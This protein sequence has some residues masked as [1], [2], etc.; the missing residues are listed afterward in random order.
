VLPGARHSLG[1]LRYVWK[2]EPIASKPD[3]EVAAATAPNL[4]RYVDGDIT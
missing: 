3:D 1:M 2:I 4:Q